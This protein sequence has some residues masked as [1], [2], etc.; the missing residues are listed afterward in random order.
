[1][2]WNPQHDNT[3][4]LSN[5]IP[6]VADLY[7]DVCVNTIVEISDL[8]SALIWSYFP[9][10]DF[11][12]TLHPQCSALR[13]SYIPSLLSTLIHSVAATWHKTSSNQFLNCQMQSSS[14][15]LT[16]WHQVMAYP[17]LGSKLPPSHLRK[18]FQPEDDHLLTISEFCSVLSIPWLIYVKSFYWSQASR[19]LTEFLIW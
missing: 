1:M 9:Y 16:W 2:H 7:Y 8:A 6:K 19:L 3:T 14:A 12:T 4:P 10:M 11:Q 18:A 13:L 15:D 5:T 17:K